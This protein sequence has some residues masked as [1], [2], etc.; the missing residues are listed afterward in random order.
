VNVDWWHLSFNELVFTKFE[1]IFRCLKNSMKKYLDAYMC[2]VYFCKVSV[3]NSIL[4]YG[5]HKFLAAKRKIAS[6]LP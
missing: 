1:I 6:F 4:V 5:K 2:S 3:K